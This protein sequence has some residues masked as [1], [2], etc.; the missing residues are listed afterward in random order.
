MSN[1]DVQTETTV[2]YLDS[3]GNGLEIGDR[4]MLNLSLTDGKWED[5]YST[6]TPG[7]EFDFGEVE[8]LNEDG[9]VGVW[10]DSAGCSCEADNPPNENPSDLTKLDDETAGVLVPVARLAHSKGYREG[11]SANQRDLRNALGLPDPTP[12][13]DN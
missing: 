5:N 7:R 6:F 8:T 12:E 3:A 2:N 11:V 9:T 10:W 13:N 4:V 1:T